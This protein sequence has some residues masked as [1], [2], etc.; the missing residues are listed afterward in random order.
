MVLK[1]SPV[2]QSSKIPSVNIAGT[3]LSPVSAVPIA[4]AAITHGI[5]AGAAAI[6]AIFPVIVGTGLVKVFMNPF[7]PKRCDPKYGTAIGGTGCAQYTSDLNY[8]YAH[9]SGVT[10]GAYRQNP[11]TGYWEQV[12]LPVTPEQ[13]A[14]LDAMYISIAQRCARRFGHCC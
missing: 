2:Q 1:P 8:W 3:T 12:H 10:P 5:V 7:P 13:Q 6:G 11:V 4:V 9:Q 14:Q